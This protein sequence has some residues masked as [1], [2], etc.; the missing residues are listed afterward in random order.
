MIRTG[1]RVTLWL[2]VALAALAALFWALVS[3][4]ESNVWMLT[5]SALLVLTMLVVAGLAVDVAIRLWRGRPLRPTGPSDLLWPAMRLVPAVALFALVWWLAGAAGA[6]VEASRGRITATLIAWFGWADPEL[7]FS[8]AAWLT[9]LAAWVAG[10]LL[11][12]GLFGALTRG[13][14]LAG[15][16]RWLRQSLSLHALAI[17]GLLVLALSRAWPW[18]EAWRPALPPTVVQLVFAGAKVALGLAGLA[19]VGA[20]FIR[21]AAMEPDRVHPGSAPPL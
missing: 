14:A 18:L 3:T 16:T 9:A 19:V 7:I 10:P 13:A 17:G 21:L 15:A 4:P 12:L 11:A 5:L 2:T 6:W 8:A 20:G 1:L